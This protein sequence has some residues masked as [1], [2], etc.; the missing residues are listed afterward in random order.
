LSATGADTEIGRISGLLSKVEVLTR[1]EMP[2]ASVVTDAQVFSPAGTGYEPNGVIRL[3][4]AAVS[5]RDHAILDELGRAAAVRGT[6]KA[7]ALEPHAGTDTKAIGTGH[8]TR[9]SHTQDCGVGTNRRS[10]R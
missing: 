4:D 9:G 3:N 10:V 6:K 7:D 8:Q 2:V 1:N 5:G